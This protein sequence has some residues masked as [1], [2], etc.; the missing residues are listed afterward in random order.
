MRMAILFIFLTLTCSRGLGS[1]VVFEDVGQVATST[2]YL[3]V[4]IP[5]NLPI[6]NQTLTTYLEMLDGIFNMTKYRHNWGPHDDRQQWFDMPITERMMPPAMKDLFQAKNSFIR[7]A[8]RFEARLK[9]LRSVLIPLSNSP[10]TSS[11]SFHFARNKRFAFVPALVA[12]GVFGTFMGLYHR[13][14]YRQLQREL[15]HQIQ[16]QNRLLSTFLNQLSVPQSNVA[17]FQYM[18]K[19]SLFAPFR[20]LAQ[21][22]EYQDEIENLF[23]IAVD[24]VETA[25][26]HRLSVT[27]FSGTQLS[28][29]FAQIQ[30]R[31]SSLGAELLLDRP[32]DLFQIETS[33]A[34]DGSDLTL[35]VHVPI[36]SKSAILRLFKYHPFPLTF[37]D[38]HFLLPRHPH[39]LFAISSDEPRLSVDLTEADLQGCYRMNGLHL[40][41]R[42]GVLNSKIQDSCLG[43]LYTQR[44]R[45]AM[46]LCEMDLLPLSEKVLQLR[47][48]WFLIYTPT[49]YTA[50]VTC[51]NH[52]SNEQHLKAGVNRILLSPSCTIKLNDH[53]LFADTSLKT[54]SSMKESQ[55]NPDDVKFP[56]EEIEEAEEVLTAVKEEGV[57]N[58][59]LADVRRLTAQN[60]RSPRW[61]YFFIL[62]GILLFV[63][64]ATWIFCFISAHKFVIIR[65][66]LR[67]MVQYLWPTQ[68]VSSRGD[69]IYESMIR[70]PGPA[71]PPN[72]HRSNSLSA[73]PFPSARRNSA[74]SLQSSEEEPHHTDGRRIPSHTRPVA[75]MTL[76]VHDRDQIRD[77]I[78]RTFRASRIPI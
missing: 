29:L 15:T 45:D 39:T 77:L 28:D 75:R 68:T 6:I 10:A 73:R 43:A 24:A 76:A 40:C 7:K 58:P 47:D 36:A 26:V 62:L 57:D 53:V 11:S 18:N 1:Y 48:N 30:G 66:A 69:A 74:P 23:D 56:D 2:A 33:Y 52:S 31:A 37:S 44:F 17:D 63:A 12:K 46:S 22:G 78:P 72:R 51:R 3:H 64:L 54:P 19:T 38:T 55:W 61:M 13:S 14:Q 8:Q 25:Q 59:T 50:F 16:E 35:V 70:R 27:L 9:N 20:L 67:A 49:A 60:K 65:K 71:S 21:L 42:L 4:T 32:S 5:V 34:F 41:E